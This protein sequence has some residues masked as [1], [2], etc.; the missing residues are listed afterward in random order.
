M[1]TEISIRQAQVCYKHKKGYATRDTNLTGQAFRALR[2]R[3][4][5][6][7]LEISATNLNTVASSIRRW[8]VCCKHK[9][10][11][12]LLLKR[13]SPGVSPTFSSSSRPAQ[14]PGDINIR[15]SK[16]EIDEE[17]RRKKGK[18][19]LLCLGRGN[20]NRPCDLLMCLY[21]ITNMLSED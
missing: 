18:N 3:L 15:A 9:K 19:L 12:M 21:S 16:H 6:R 14:T 20:L 2:F 13:T 1:N 4:G 17:K 11:V 5:G 7:V 8:Q 10:G